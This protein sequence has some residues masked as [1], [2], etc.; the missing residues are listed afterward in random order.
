M[1]VS[2]QNCAR[3]IAK[4]CQND[5]RMLMM[6]L[7]LMM[8]IMMM[9]DDADDDYDDYGADDDACDTVTL[10]MKITIPQHS[11]KDPLASV[12]NIQ[13]VGIKSLSVR[14]NEFKVTK[15]HDEAYDHFTRKATTVS[16]KVFDATSTT[17]TA[18]GI[19]F[20]ALNRP[21]KSNRFDCP[22]P[23]R[24]ALV[25]VNTLRAFNVL[26]REPKGLETWCHRLFGHGS[27]FRAKPGDTDAFHGAEAEYYVVL[28]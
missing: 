13:A 28:L 14:H 20:K 23:H 7:M 3:I 22:H 16:P 19:E 21:T 15:L 11:E 4:S 27:L 5:A 12:A 10:L 1:P 6:M 2:Y 8:M 17:E 9:K 18:C 26:G 25:N 24:F